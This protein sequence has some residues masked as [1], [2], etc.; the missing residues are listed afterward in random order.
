MRGKHL[1]G[2]CLAI[3]IAAGRC[4]A[5][6]AVPDAE[7]EKLRSCYSAHPGAPSWTAV[8]IR[9]EQFFRDTCGAIAVF[10]WRE[11]L[12]AGYFARLIWQESHFDPFALSTAGAQGIAQFIPS[13]ARLRGLRN[14]FDPTEALAK[15]ADYLRFLTDKYGNLGLAAAAYNGGEGRTSRYVAAGGY[16]PS[17]TRYYVEL[18]TGRD[19]DAWLAE[20]PPEVDYALGK[21]TPFIDACVKMAEV[22]RVPSMDRQPGEWMPW[23]VLVAQNFSQGVAIRRFERVQAAYPK[24]LGKE[25]LM[26][27]MARNPSFG[28][29]LRHYAMIGRQNRAEADELCARL[30]AAGGSCIVRKN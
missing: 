15:S 8:C 11:S 26:L 1:I 7:P 14:A 24:V 10:A 27:L 17:E 6:A 29:R 23:G 2:L 28:P 22:E 19:A 5:E 25:K 12:P 13:T 18:I 30:Q 21:D 16:L 3:A 4:A 20:T 9:Q